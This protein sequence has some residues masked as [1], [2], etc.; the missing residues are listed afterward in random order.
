MA[1]AER[2]P[3]GTGRSER[4]KACTQGAG[5]GGCATA[6]L[7]PPSLWP[8]APQRIN[9]L[10]PQ[11]CGLLGATT[12][13]S[14]GPTPVCPRLTGSLP[15]QGA[16]AQQGRAR[17][18]TWQ[19]TRP[20]PAQACR[21]TRAAQSWGGERASS[22]AAGRGRGVL[23]GG[24]AGDGKARRRWRTCRQR[25]VRASQHARMRVAAGAGSH[26]RGGGPTHTCHSM[27]AFSAL[28]T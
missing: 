8:L 14:P 18:C 21:C 13:R 20:R 12:D 1:V 7:C 23:G 9:T 16:R 3:L 24:L 25:A 22:C 4:W 2:L 27:S 15:G 17:Q 28:I 11:P 6:C 10:S 5:G 19:R 26:R